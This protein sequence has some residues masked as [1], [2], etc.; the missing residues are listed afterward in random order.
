MTRPLM[1]C[2]Q[3][4]SNIGTEQHGRPRGPQQKQGRRSHGSL[5]VAAESDKTRSAESS[6][7]Q[8]GSSNTGG[9]AQQRLGGVRRPLHWLEAGENRSLLVS[10]PSLSS[11]LPSPPRTHSASLK[12]CWHLACRARGP[13]KEARS[14]LGSVSIRGRSLGVIREAPQKRP[15][16]HWDLR[17]QALTSQTR[18]EE[19]PGRPGRRAPGILPVSAGRCGE[20][21]RGPRPGVGGGCGRRHTLGRHAPGTGRRPRRPGGRGTASARARAGSP[22][23]VG[24]ARNGAAGAGGPGRA[25]RCWLLLLLLCLTATPG[26]PGAAGGRSRRHWPVPY[27]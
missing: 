21:P 12:R 5:E 23:S 25:P 4:Q 26:W 19:A 13:R 27:K 24:M 20:P 16:L 6:L 8:R 2:S 7:Q 15:F 18:T 3:R 11:S 10:S 22:A 9:Q 14:Q 1:S 17:P